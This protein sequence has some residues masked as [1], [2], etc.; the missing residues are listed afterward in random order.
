MMSYSWF[1]D[2]VEYIVIGPD[3][4]EQATFVAYADFQ[5]WFLSRGVDFAQEILVMEYSYNDN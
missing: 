4:L 1:P 5:Q 2:K 3:G